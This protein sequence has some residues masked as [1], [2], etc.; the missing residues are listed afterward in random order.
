MTGH[1]RTRGVVSLALA[2]LVA[3]GCEKTPPKVELR[4]R[5]LPDDA[6]NCPRDEVAETLQQRLQI[7]GAPGATVRAEWAQRL[8]IGLPFDDPAHVEQARRV[9]EVLGRLE[10]RLV[11]APASEVYGEWMRGGEGKPPAGYTVYT[12]PSHRED[13]PTP[14]KLL[15]S[16]RVEM[17]GEHI[18]STRVIPPSGTMLRPA[19]G[20]S[21][22]DV[23]EK[24]FAQVTGANVGRRLAVVMNTLRGPDGS[25]VETGV[26]HTAPVIR[27]QI[28]GDAVI[29]GSFSES[30]AKAIRTVLMAGML[31]A[32]VVFEGQST[33]A[34]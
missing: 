34:P 18:K 2:A 26:C 9:I 31:A 15:V 11:A 27:T 17:T 28:A 13:D 4:Y 3:V 7:W 14:E 33:P 1:C 29:E 10:F 19:V 8:V 22:T 12:I 32:P 30:D 24:Q 20:I 21:F 23:G 5:V 6:G 25:I 16:D